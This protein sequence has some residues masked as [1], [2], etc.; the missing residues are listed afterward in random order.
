MLC[1][2]K[3]NSLGAFVS[4]AVFTAAAGTLTAFAPASA[5]AQ[6]T[7]VGS[8]RDR[9]VTSD[10]TIQDLAAM[11]VGFSNSAPAGGRSAVFVFLLPAIAPGTLFTSA[12]LDLFLISTIV[13]GGISYNVDLYGLRLN[14]PTGTSPVASGDYFSGP[15]DTTD[16]TLIQDNFAFVGSPNGF[17]STNAAGD[18]ALLRFINSQIGAGAPV[19]SQLLFRLSPDLASDPDAGGFDFQ[20]GD[21]ASPAAN[22]P[23]L[24]LGTTPLQVIPEPGTLALLLTGVAGAAGLRGTR[25]RRRRCAS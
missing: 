11:R 24:T 4:V 20:S 10:G 18:A 3:R 13:P 21:P 6:T 15:L 17:L 25:C 14:P 7:I 1:S 9:V 22:R 2:T 23:V 12:N 16:A 8:A 19:N 5:Q